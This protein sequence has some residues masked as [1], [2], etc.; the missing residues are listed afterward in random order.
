VSTSATLSISLLEN[1]LASITP[2]SPNQTTLTNVSTVNAA[3]KITNDSSGD[4]Q[5]TLT[6]DTVTLLKDLAL[7]NT[8]GAN[9]D[10]ARLQTDLKA[11]D[12]STTSTRINQALTSLLRD[13]NV[14]NKSAVNSDITELKTALQ[15]QDQSTANIKAASNQNVGVTNLLSKINDSLKSGSIQGALQDLAGYLV[16]NGQVTGSLLNVNA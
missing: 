3:P 16:Q 15:T 10:L 13:L 7:G 2:S 4:S 6:N 12:A 9:T 5:N 14:G 11:Q 8:S 1:S